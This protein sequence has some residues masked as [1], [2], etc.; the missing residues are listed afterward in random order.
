MTGQSWTH[1]NIGQR[2]LFGGAN[3]V[4]FIGPS[5]RRIYR[6]VDDYTLTNDLRPGGSAGDV[7][8]YDQTIPSGSWHNGDDIS[9]RWGAD[10]AK[11]YVDKP[12]LTYSVA[13]GGEVVHPVA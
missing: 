6:T 7:P 12:R 1:K 8:P 10:P 9:L 4:S 5:G 2:I 11:V 3:G 13:Y